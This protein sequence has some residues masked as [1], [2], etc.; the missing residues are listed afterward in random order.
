MKF[1]YYYPGRWVPLNPAVVTGPVYQKLAV[2]AEEAGFWGISMDE[3]PAPIAPWL[4]QHGHH[5]I[6]PFVCL[7]AAGA[8]TSKLKL[9]TYLAILPYRN[10]FA[11]AKTV[12]SVDVM[13]GGRLIL[14]AGTGYLK[15]EFDALGVDF[16]QRNALFE[17][18]VEVYRKS[19]S[20]DFVSHR[21]SNFAGK[22][23]QIL[24]AAVQQ[25]HPPIWLGGNSHLTMR[26]V[27][28][29]G[30]GWLPM[31]LSRDAPGMHKTP[32]LE[33][34]EDLGIYVDY[35]REHAER[36]GR[37]DPIEIIVSSGL[38]NLNLPMT[39]IIDQIKAYQAAGATGFTIN[40][41][42]ETPQMAEEFVR[43]FGAEV[44]PA[45]N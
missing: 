23:V 30:G 25:P 6:D 15:G 31:P 11:L 2:A 34:P 8:V 5:C 36:N 42:G 38:L 29:Y 35:L 19:C 40:G 13:T 32:P 9:V 27:A 33:T 24:P 12:T 39:A 10:P 1:I 45:F 21:G 17:E 41:I 7:T 26:R 43:K 18:V 4:D 16:D 20:G 22:D 44:I 3:H 37:T 28:E 14:G